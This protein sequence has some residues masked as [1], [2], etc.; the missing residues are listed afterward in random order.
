M[1]DTPEEGLIP[2]A[3]S[4]EKSRSLD[5]TIDPVRVPSFPA[6]EAPPSGLEATVPL[7]HYYWLFRRNAWRIGF[8]VLAATLLALALSMQMVPI[9]EATVTIDVDR[10]TPT[11][12]IGQDSNRSMSNDADQYLATQVKM[13]QSDSVLRPVVDRY[14]LP[15]RKPSRF[16]LVAP[17]TEQQQ[18]DAPVMLD[19]LKV[20]RP[21]NT[22]LMLVSYRSADPK[23]AADTVNAIAN[24]YLDHSYNIRYQSSVGLSHFMEKQLDELHAKMEHSSAALLQFERDLNV[25]SPEEKTN[26]I[27]ARLLQLNQEY[28]SA[29]ADRV[30][31]ESAWRSIEGGSVAAAQVSTQGETMRKLDE[32]LSEARQKLS[33]VQVHFGANHPENRKATA[34]VLEL[35][36]QLV[37]LKTNIQQRVNVEFLEASSRENMLELQVRAAKRELDLLNSRSFEYQNLRREA[38]ADKKLYEELVRKIREAGINASFQNSAIRI[39]DLARTPLE[40]VSPNLILNTGLAFLLSLLLAVGGVLLM[41]ALDNTIRDPEQ[42]KLGLGSELL[43]TLPEV[44]TWRHRIG[45]ANNMDAGGALVRAA[46]DG[47]SAMSGY[48]ESIRTLRNAI[49]LTN[50]DRNLRSLLVT[51]AQPGEGKSTVAAHLALTHAMQGAKTLLIDGDMRRPSVHRRFAIENNLGLCGYLQGKGSLEELI[52]K[53][54]ASENLHIL[55]AGSPNRRPDDWLRGRM[56]S[57][58]ENLL[59]DYQLVILD[60]PPLL[61]FAEPLEMATSVDGVIVVTRAGSTSRKQVGSVLEMLTRLRANVLGVVLNQVNKSMGESYSYY[62]YYGKY[63]AAKERG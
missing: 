2:L 55:T 8:F 38:D 18:K 34:Q 1:V 16:R 15:L 6:Q 3:R 51:S 33:E 27:S 31:K 30:K 36:K 39:A 50:F 24:S 43:G 7:S 26:I 17:Y 49:L 47:Y 53:S 59:A 52:Q 63:Y 4:L 42:I 14:K 35:E 23:L 62:G 22:Y 25:I 10:Q 60:A 21:P 20:S 28:T 29:Q 54:E 56:D 48:E 58:V 5:L 11:G 61:G 9:Y 57:I 44:K 19:G 13:L 37:A 40:P 12:V 46:K 41:D 32:R 45:L